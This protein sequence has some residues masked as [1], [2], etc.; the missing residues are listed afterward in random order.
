M[1]MKNTLKHKAFAIALSVAMLF[2]MMPTVALDTNADTVPN[3]TKVITSIV[4]SDDLK[5]QPI[6]VGAEQEPTLPVKLDAEVTTTTWEEVTTPVEVEGAEPQTTVSYVPT[7]TVE[8]V[9]VDVTWLITGG[10]TFSTVQANTFSYTAELTDSTY[11][12]S[13]EVKPVIIV[14]V[15]D[16]NS[17]AAPTDCEVTE[18]CE[19]DAGH[20]G[21]C[22]L[23][24]TANCEIMEN[25]ELEVGHEE[26]C[27]MPPPANY[28]SMP[29]LMS[30]SNGLVDNGEGYLTD[31][32]GLMAYKYTGNNFD[33]HG[34]FDGD[35]KQ[36]TYQDSGFATFLK[37]G[38]STSN[39]RV[40][41]VSSANGGHTVDSTELNVA[42]DLIIQNEGQIIEVKYTVKNNNASDLTFSLGSGEDIQIGASDSAPITSFDGNTGFKMV[43]T[44]AADKNDADEYAQFNTFL[45][46]APGVDDVSGYW[47]GVWSTYSANVFT[48]LSPKDPL[49]NTDSGATWHWA[50]KTIPAGATQSYSI[51]LGIGGKG[52]ENAVRSGVDYAKEQLSELDPNAVYKITVDGITHELT[53]DANGQIP[54]TTDEYTFIG[55]TITIVKKG[56]DG[57][58]DSEASEVEV[59]ARPP[60]PTLEQTGGVIQDATTDLEYSL[61]GG[62]TWSPIDADGALDEIYE[63]SETVLLRVKATN[64]APAGPAQNFDFFADSLPQWAKDAGL[65]ESNAMWNEAEQKLVLKDNVT[66][67][68]TLEVPDGSNV[69]IKVH[70]NETLTAPTGK[71]AITTNSDLNIGGDGTIKGGDADADGNGSPA[72][73]STGGSVTIDED[74][75]VE[76][77]DA[78]T[79]NGGSAIE[80]TGNTT[81]ITNNGT[82]TG[83]ASDSGTG[84]SGITSDEDI[85]VAGSGSVTGGN[86]T[87]GAGGDG[88]TGGG[89]VTTNEGAVTG[90]SGATNGGDGINSTGGNSNITTGTGSVNG[91]SGGTDGGDGINTT[92]NN[93]N[94][95]TGAGSINGGSGGTGDGGDG[96]ASTGDVSTGGNVN[97]GASTNGTGGNGI[98]SGGNVNTSG[99]NVTGG[100]S[101]AGTGG[102]GIAVPKDKDV[103]VGDD[104]E[105]IGGNNSGGDEG[106]GIVIDDDAYNIDYINGKITVKDG[107][108]AKIKGSS[109]AFSNIVTFEPNTTYEIKKS[110]GTIAEFTTASRSNKPAV[111]Q[112]QESVENKN[113]GTIIGATDKME[114][115]TDGGTTWNDVSTLPLTGFS[116]ETVS[117][118]IK[119]THNTPSSETVNFSFTASTTTLSVTFNAN[120]GSQTPAQSGIV[121][122]DKITVV[123]PTKTGH[124]FDGWYMDKAF[125]NYWGTTTGAVFDNYTLEAKWIADSEPKYEVSGNITL[126]VGGNASG[127]TIEI[128][129]GK[130]LINSTTTD[131]NG[132]YSFSDI[133]SG[134]YNI[135]IKSGV[136]PNQKIKTIITTV[137]SGNLTINAQLPSKAVS[138]T[139]DVKDGTP[140]VVV[141]GL[142]K[143]AENENPGPGEEIE[144]KLEVESKT[145]ESAPADEVAAITAIATNKGNNNLEFIDMLVIKTTTSGAGST[146]EAMSNT[147]AVLEI[148][149]PYDMTGKQNISV[150]RY[151]NNEATAFDKLATRPT[152]G[153]TDGTYYVGPDYIAIYTN[154]FSTYAVGYTTFT[155]DGSGDI[156]G[157]PNTGDDSPINLMIFT[158]MISII[159]MIFVIKKRRET[160][161]LIAIQNLKDNRPM[162]F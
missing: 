109:D 118:R 86:S 39:I 153:F 24:A 69:T 14:N 105:I 15:V 10:A 33:I 102:N 9:E 7:T 21:D 54:L 120:G 80:V 59:G 112:K 41:A 88:I 46:D 115:S 94:V 104:S 55:K 63:Q 103:T 66:L 5:T 57:A 150:Y 85:T 114:Y 127:V 136:A 129:K 83:G 101:T 107:Y 28:G 64:E 30:L 142:D 134:E 45:K 151:H 143:V 36:V 17:I 149:V 147:S 76:G 61:D 20:E 58:D 160:K 18:N 74:S 161:K 52:S 78:T 11:E 29:N 128:Y 2:S 138:S 8:I 19:L 95:N 22:Q 119:A 56:T 148:I 117:I 124:T 6:T 96:I 70:E 125:T 137:E 155:N 1:Y 3:D 121:Y 144:L 154:Q 79:G 89:N 62:K 156:T 141:G 126:G 16:D 53:A 34:K 140:D 67:T 40:N 116:D 135:V 139:V 106:G 75:T 27:Q 37:V 123:E 44:N 50:D 162:I 158:M 110:D 159:G 122:G 32:Y 25:C 113:D 152:S 51:K 26:E 68:D 12:I 71:P 73:S 4:L 133:P 82:A 97:G 43:S 145:A 42:I 100:D 38:A 130:N 77:G 99:G 72:I 132:N 47:Y 23:P 157:A 13:D 60:A 93:S 84:G 90:G 35:W 111:T 87:S 131:V 81:T 98:T 48:D 31:S 108:T 65:N 49:T 92:G 91:G 146:V